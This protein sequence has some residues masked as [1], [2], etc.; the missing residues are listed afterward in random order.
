MKPARSFS[1]PLLLLVP[2]LLLLL[3]STGCGERDVDK[4][5]AQLKNDF[6]ADN[7]EDAAEKL[8]KLD[9]KAALPALRAATRDP[10]EEVREAAAEALGRLADKTSGPALV[11]LLRDSEKKVRQ[12]AVKAL[13]LIGDPDRVNDLLPMLGDRSS[14]IREEAAESL[15]RIGSA[16]ALPAL[17]RLAAEDRDDDVRRV[18]AF[19]AQRIEERV[20]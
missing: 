14:D 18:A 16:L 2:F 5:I 10:D 1:L 17:R 8:G 12:E 6:D 4:Y 20:Q 13:G 15:G 9:D 7:R 19:A 3:V 11:A